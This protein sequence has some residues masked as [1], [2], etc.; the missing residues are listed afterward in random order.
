MVTRKIGRAPCRQFSSIL[1]IPESKKVQKSYPHLNFPPEK[2]DIA[3]LG[4][5][6]AVTW[7]VNESPLC[8]SP[9]TTASFTSA[10]KSPQC[11]PKVVESECW[12]SLRGTNYT[13]T[14]DC[15]HLLFTSL[16]LSSNLLHIHLYIYTHSDTG[17]PAERL[18]LSDLNNHFNFPPQNLPSMLGRFL[19]CEF[20]DQPSS[21][22]HLSLFPQNKVSPKSFS[23]FLFDIL[24]SREVFGRKGRIT[25]SCLVTDSC[26]CVE[27]R[28]LNIKI[29]PNKKKVCFSPALCFIYLF[30]FFQLYIYFSQ[31][32]SCVWRWRYKIRKKHL[33][34]RKQANKRKVEV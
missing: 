32:L 17:S 14:P 6:W 20:V 21:L 4:L 26:L 18:L 8:G 13:S 31:C 28:F 34:Q 25:T 24:F 9:Q 15:S 23:P 29:S 30:Q 2:T 27:W 7:R 3:W 16:I 11:S 19:F 12:L 1:A 10:L 5:S 33:I 22:S